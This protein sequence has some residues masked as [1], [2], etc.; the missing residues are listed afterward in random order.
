MKNFL[1]RLF[2]SL[3]FFLIFG[4]IF[5][6]SIV[7]YLQK[8]SPIADEIIVLTSDTI[9]DDTSTFIIAHIGREVPTPSLFVL[10]AK[11][12]VLVPNGYGEYELGAVLPLLTLEEKDATYTRAVFSRILGVPVQR[13]LT[14]DAHVATSLKSEAFAKLKNFKIPWHELAVLELLEEGS[15]DLQ[16]DSIA[17][18]QKKLQTSLVRV[19]SRSELACTL[20]IV[21][22]TEET[23]LAGQLATILEQ[24]G[25]RVV[26]IT[27]TST[28]QEN[29]SLKTGQDRPECAW[30]V[31]LITAWFYSDLTVSQ[32]AEVEKSYRAWGVVFIGTDAQ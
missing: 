5:W 16:A 2:F 1:R 18:V 25:V 32:S 28:L 24:S 6:Q 9:D 17:E 14:V 7:F 10:P 29:S 27:D 20:A 12:R 26:K 22:T 31:P 8:N 19:V 15:E 3:V 11:L 13:I 23:G 4:W 21:N 30:I